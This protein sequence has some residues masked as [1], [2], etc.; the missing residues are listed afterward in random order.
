MI[1]AITKQII[2]SQ[3]ARLTP[4]SPIRRLAHLS[5]QAKANGTKVYHL[6]IGQPDIETPKEFLDGIKNYSEKV[7]AYEGSAGNEQLRKAWSNYMNASL[8]LSTEPAQFLITT[9]ASEALIFVFMICCDPGDEIIIFDP[10]YANY[11]GFAAIAGVRL[12]PVP[13]TMDSNFSL[14]SRF[15][16]EKR[17]TSRTKAILL[18][19]PNNPTGTVYSRDELQMIVNLCN[20]KNIFCVVDETYREFV[21]GDRQP[22][23]VLHLDPR[24]DKIIVVD[25]LSK[26]F[27]LC[28]GRLG[29]LLTSNKEVLQMSLNLAQARLSSPTIEQIAAAQMLNSISSDFLG[30]AIKEYEKRR[31]TLYDGLKAING[32]NVHKPEGAFYAIA[33]LPIE[34]AEDFASYML[35]DFSYNGATTFVA[36]AA[37]FYMEGG[38]GMSK[39]RIAY[40]LNSEDIKKAISI[41]E[42]GLTKY[43][44]IK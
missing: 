14:P 31:D 33:K 38:R 19:S 40:V 10:T 41:L 20:E 34:N 37:G 5:T 32:V 18:C 44:S 27:S 2:L 23:S 16:I 26:R 30:K 25:S 21:Y 29:C 8:G 35:R 28:G 13:C 24:N 7:L 11:I 17:I 39:I 4:P 3:R 36:P 43:K 12:V 15:E 22:L 42:A 9:G 6:N 1:G